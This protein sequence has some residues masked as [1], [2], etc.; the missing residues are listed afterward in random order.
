MVLSDLPEGS[1]QPVIDDLEKACHGF[2]LGWWMACEATIVKNQSLPSAKIA[3]T[4]VE[5][6]SWR[7]EQKKQAEGGDFALIVVAV[8]SQVVQRVQDNKVTE[9]E[10]AE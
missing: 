3:R 10:K 6:V 8:N 4:L 7:L 2:S 1:Q 9:V 5:F